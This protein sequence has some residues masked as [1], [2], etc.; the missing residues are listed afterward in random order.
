M[1]TYLNTLAERITALAN[2]QS[3]VETAAALLTE[4]QTN[5]RL[6]HV[7][8]TEPATASLMTEVFFRAGALTNINPILDP[9]LDPAHGA[10]RNEMCMQLE[11]LSPCILDYYE[12][13]EAGEPMLLMGTDPAAPMFAEALAWAKNKGLKTIAFVCRG[14]DC[15]A[16]VVLHH[17]ALQDSLGGEQ[18]VL[19]C[20]LLHA[21]NDKAAASLDDSHVW[22]GT[23]TVDLSANAAR[24]DERLFRIRHL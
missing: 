8:G 24:I 10:Y 23:H 15:D 3:A 1:N 5:N 22:H 9:S 4:A 6:I 17:G 11:G 18:S 7:F 2:E 19:L 20:A 16:D 12:Y 14:C 21:V 13:V